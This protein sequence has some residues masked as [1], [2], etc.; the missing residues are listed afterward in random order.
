M[1]KY[2]DFSILLTT[3]FLTLNNKALAL[4]NLINVIY[5]MLPGQILIILNTQIFITFSWIKSILTGFRFCLQL[6]KNFHERVSWIKLV[7]ICDRYPQFIVSD[8]F[9]FYNNQCLTVLIKFSAQLTEIRQAH[10]LV[11]KN[12]IRNAK[13][14][15]CRA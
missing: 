10:G 7:Y 8:I 5:M 14:R 2:G 15:K 1:A 12:E 4:F 3:I 11:T 13:F 6:E 9:K